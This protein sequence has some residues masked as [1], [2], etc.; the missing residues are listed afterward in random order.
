NSERHALEIRQTGGRGMKSLVMIAL[1]LLP[2]AASAGV[3]C[4][5]ISDPDQRALCRA[6]TTKSAGD[7]TFIADY[8]LRQACRARVTGNANPCN[9][10][11][12]QWEREKC[13]RE[14]AH[15]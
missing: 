11:T 1:L 9:T 7:C 3:V 6:T 4:A 5:T 15:R 2:G 10:V 13:R 12:S 8:S 14:A